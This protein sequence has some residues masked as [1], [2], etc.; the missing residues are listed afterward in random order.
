MTEQALLQQILDELRQ[1][2]EQLELPRPKPHHRWLRPRDLYP[3][4]WSRSTVYRW[5][6]NGKLRAK[7]VGGTLLIDPVSVEELVTRGEA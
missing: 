7:R 4:P 3:R 2:R 6:G 1:I 5:I